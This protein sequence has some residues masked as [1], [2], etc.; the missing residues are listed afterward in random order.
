MLLYVS[1]KYS[2]DTQQ[3]IDENVVAAA[4]MAA[5]LMEMGHTVICPH[6]NS[7]GIVEAGG[8]FSWDR[9]WETYNSI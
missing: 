8:H 4:E 6:T 5:K 2:A 1:G 7:H 3:E 9:D